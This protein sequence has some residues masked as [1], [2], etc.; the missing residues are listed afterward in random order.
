MRVAG[1][2]DLDGTTLKFEQ[3][4]D[5]TTITSNS[6]SSDITLTLPSSASMNLV[7]II[8]GGTTT[9][10]V[11]FD[12][13]GATA[14][15]KL[16]IDTNHTDNRT[17]TIQD[18][19]DTF[20]G[21]ATTDTLTNKTL[22]SPTINT[23]TLT[24][25][26]A[27]L[28]IQDNSDTSKKLQFQVSG[29]SASTTRT[30]TV[31]DANTTIVGTDAT[32]T[33]TNKTLTTPV[34][35]VNDDEW[36]MQ[37]DGDSGKKMTF[38]LSGITTG[39]TRVMTIPDASTT[40]VGTDTT[41]TL[42]NK[43]LT[44]PV[45]TTPTMTAGSN[46]TLTQQAELR[47]EDSSGGEYFALEAP[48]S[49]T[50][51]YTMSVPSDAPT[52]NSQ[53]LCVTDYTASPITTQWASAL[54]D[55]LTDQHMFIG[56]SSNV[57]TAVDTQL[58][59]NVEAKV[60]SATFVDGDVALTADRITA[61]AHG[62]ETGDRVFLTTTGTLPTG[63]SASTEYFVIKVDADTLELATTLAN[64]ID[65]TQIDITAASGGGTHT[66][67]A[68]G[69]EVKSTSLIKVPTITLPRISDSTDLTKDIV[70]TLSGATTAKTL[71]LISS[72]TDD[73]ALTLPDATDTLVGRATTDTLTNKTLTSPSISAATISG[74]QTLS[75]TPVFSGACTF[76]G[77]AISLDNA[78][79][80][81]DSAA[82]VDF[83]VKGD[84]D[85]ALL[86][87]DASTDRIGVGTASPSNKF[88]I[89][90]TSTPQ[91]HVESTSGSSAGVVMT[92]TEGAAT[93]RADANTLQLVVNSTE[94]VRI[95]D[96]GVVTIGDTSGGTSDGTLYVKNVQ[97]T[98]VPPL[99]VWNP[100][101]ST[102]NPLMRMYSNVSGS[103]SLKWRVEA[104]GDTI[105]STGSYTS[106]ARAKKQVRAIPYGLAEIK[107]LN[108]IGFRWNH[109][110]DD[111]VE[112]FSA[113]TA[114]NIQAI[115]PELV[116]DDGL[117]QMDSDGN[118]F[119]AKSVYDKELIAVL[120]QAV[121]ELEARVA[122]LEGP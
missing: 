96:D 115:M 6:P 11:V 95:T 48:S 22:T 8:H 21:L 87:V 62:L 32:Q 66:I 105:S 15:K 102:T 103:E 69:L 20:V 23:P 68:G 98:T 110:E 108:P 39:N 84:T 63:L 47:F 74:T 26:D 116:R 28:T 31:P 60:L 90:S 122:V 30:L 14:A 36:T 44:S 85:A 121:K 88:H 19:T 24:V 53:A 77:G 17:W 92:N 106:D 12:S 75:S 80:I 67:T 79:T 100:T 119:Q 72:Q 118:V 65:G 33:L 120:I 42:T 29:V 101:V 7:G 13:Q 64:A 10:D 82:D 35:T 54:T 93:V 34:V 51:N 57:S 41:Q 86:V 112:S 81:N 4:G 58:V 50:S 43:T 3:G 83:T 27:S 40:L 78:V 76:S 114:Q 61:T 97:A 91:L 38:Q 59:G 52:A 73:R 109:E 45:L 70:I 9:K 2:L 71:T 89:Q 113:D 5:S 46:L 18:S 56:N 37:D 16:T 104:D 55:T 49:I 117:D 99:A 107:Q 111:E 25:N 94:R 1:N